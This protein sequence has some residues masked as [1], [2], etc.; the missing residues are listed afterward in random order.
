MPGL[1]EMRAGFVHEATVELAAGADQRAPGAAVTVALCG[2]WE[3]DGACAVPHCTVVDR[4]A[5]QSLQVRV[6]FACVPTDEAGVRRRIVAALAAGTL[7]GPD[8]SSEWRL[9]G[10]RP[11]RLRAYE[12]AQ[13]DRWRAP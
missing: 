7:V 8:G 12:E 13:S 2:S 5:A 9:V 6:V 4:R 3:H 1:L 11:D 10:P